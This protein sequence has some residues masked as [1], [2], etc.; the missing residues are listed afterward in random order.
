MNIASETFFNS[1]LERC[2]YRYRDIKIINK[3]CDITGTVNKNVGEKAK[4]SKMN[5]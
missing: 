2:S 4:K 5:I 3:M 1:T